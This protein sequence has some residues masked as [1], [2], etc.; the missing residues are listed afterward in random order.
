MPESDNKLSAKI[1]E[2]RLGRG[3]TQKE[4]AGCRITRNMLSLI[5]SGRATPSI[6]TLKYISERLDAPAGYFFTSSADDESKFMK[7]LIIDEL[8]T[9]F[10]EKKYAE[11]QKI[12]SAVPQNHLDDELTYILAVSDFNAAVDFA[13][14]YEMSKALDMFA[15]AESEAKSSVYI[16]DSFFKA[17]AYY[18][19]LIS[20]IGSGDISDMLCD[21]GYCSDYVPNY[22]VMYFY[23]VR[24]SRSGMKCSTGFPRGSYYDKHVSAI[25]LLADGHTNEALKRLRE[26]VQDQT[27]P[28]YMQYHVL[29]DLERAANITGDL[30]LA[31]NSSH[32]K[33][34][35]IERCKVY[36]VT[37]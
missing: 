20:S 33:L 21:T 10:A 28:Y 15:K 19:E 34:D 13:A 14:A 17:A 4:L 7:L 37:Q 36:R 35:L 11:C 1:K 26:L 12:L 2:L 9:K 23:F 29:D 31:Y 25:A 32:K 3:I 18:R 24:L 16:T 30:K 6:S 5:E 27:L 22:T 8:K